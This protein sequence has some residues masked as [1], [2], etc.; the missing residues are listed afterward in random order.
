VEDGA[1]FVRHLCLIVGLLFAQPSAAADWDPFEGPGPALV[2]VERN[3]WTSPFGADEPRVA[4]YENGDAI[5]FGT[6]GSNNGYRY[7]RLGDPDLRSLL[8]R[9][10]TT[11]LAKG[12]RPYY[13]VSEVTDQPTTDIYFKSSS[14][15]MAIE[16]YGLGCEQPMPFAPFAG[17]DKSAMPP[18]ESLVELTK[19]LCTLEIA[20]SEKWSPRFIQVM[21]WDYA[22][23]PGNSITWP[24]DWP[25]L[26]SPRAMR[27]GDIYSIF[28][29]AALL[30]QLKSLFARQGDKGAIVIDGKKMAV[31]ARVPFPSEPVW[32]SAFEHMRRSP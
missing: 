16:V 3:A 24:E 20:G 9:A 1:L 32:R 25:S 2:L 12:L 8:Q 5:Y 26:T 15:S 31:S 23:A 6:D 4:I 28:L 27:R 22:Y 19:W 10:A 29:E 18:P 14:G 13:S 21:M 30:P 17:H 7:K 11:L